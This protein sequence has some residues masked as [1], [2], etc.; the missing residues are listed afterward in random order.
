MTGP[1]GLGT[2]PNITDPNAAQNFSRDADAFFQSL[3]TFE[4][5]LAAYGNGVS[6]GFYSA[7]STSVTVPSAGASVSMTAAT[8]KGFAVG[9]RVIV[10]STSAPSANWF[11]ATVTNYT[12]GTGALVLMV[13][14][15]IGADTVSSWSITLSQPYVQAGSF[16]SSATSFAVPAIGASVSLTA[17]TLRTWQ[18]GDTLQ[19]VSTASPS[20]VRFVGTVNS[21]S[22]ST[23]ALSLTCK[24]AR[25]SGTLAAWT[26]TQAVNDTLLNMWTA[27]E[28]GASV[29]LDLSAANHFTRTVGGA[30]TF[31]FS[32]APSGQAFGFSLRVTHT[33]GAITWPAS[34]VWPEGA[35]PSLSSGRVHL[36][37]FFTDDGG[38]KWR[39]SVLSNY[40]A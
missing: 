38:T 30:T 12:S 5:N 13:D 2:A 16:G 4:T 36:F 31:A 33:S 8:G 1:L 15:S 18:V 26:I 19:V 28:S 3:S 29:T 6:L 27:V 10:A 35:A 7:S 40:T 17:N 34:V 32:N 14:F 25:G 21:Y 37:T 22:S 20:A 9:Q 23:G 24:W 39:G 11:Y